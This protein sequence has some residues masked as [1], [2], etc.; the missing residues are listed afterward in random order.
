MKHPSRLIAAVSLMLA[1]Q[2]TASPAD[3]ERIKKS[4]ESAAKKWTQTSRAA[5]T[6]EAKSA[7]LATRP[8]P[9]RFATQMWQEISPSLSKDWTLEYAA[10]LLNLTRTISTTN[11]DGMKVP[12]FSEE[13]AAIR[14]AVT[15]YHLKSPALTPMCM[16]LALSQDPGTLSIL[17]KIESS[18]PDPKI[19][20]VA[21]LASALVIKS[22]GDDAEPMRKRLTHLR[23]A[24]IQSSDVKIGEVSVADIAEDELYIIR[25]LTK[26]RV[27][28][29]LV[30][31]DAAGRAL[32]LE[33]TKG[34]ITMLLFWN[35]EMPESDRVLEITNNTL[36]KFKGRP[37]TIIGV[38]HDPLAK[39][40]SIEADQ[41]TSWKNF[42][43]PNMKLAREY[44]INALPHVLIL[45]GERKIHYSG[46]PGSFAEITAE[47]LLSEAN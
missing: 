22:L 27:A 43:D 24:I 10:W 11:A 4:W 35:S 14:K 20:G 19:Q 37:F 18:H 31:T 32:A 7:A 33:S 25:N 1:V 3:A 30:G 26:G 15:S 2:A 42:S 16:A 28:P 21:A 40:R 8:D 6:P 12:A 13:S 46:V 5:T 34:K 47:A 9:A 38:N 23:K 17:E 29:N 39:L 45:D 36:R 41:I 44:R